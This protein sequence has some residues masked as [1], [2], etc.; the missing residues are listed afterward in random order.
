MIEI[1]VWLFWLLVANALLKMLWPLFA[2]P[3]SRS[4]VEMLFGGA[5]ALA[6]LLGFG[7]A[8]RR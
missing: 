1:P 4:R 3:P 8:W 2:E 7:E 6:L 5:V